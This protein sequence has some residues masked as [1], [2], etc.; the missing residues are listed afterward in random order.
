M[1]VGCMGSDD[2]GDISVTT[3]IEI[4]NGGAVVHVVKANKKFT[5]E[6]DKDEIKDFVLAVAGS[7]G[8]G[9]I[10][11]DINGKK[12]TIDSGDDLLIFKGIEVKE[13]TYDIS[14]SVLDTE[15]NEIESID[16]SIEVKFDEESSSS[17]MQSSDDNKSSEEPA[18]S[19]DD[20]QSSEDPM[21]SEDP[22]SSDDPKSSEDPMSSDDPKS[23]E[24]PMSSDDPKSSED[25]MSSEDPKSSE[26]PMSS[27]SDVVVS[28]EEPSSSSEEP[29]TDLKV[30]KLE[31]AINRTRVQEIADGSVIEIAAEDNET[32]NFYAT[33]EGGEA[34]SVK[35]DA[36]GWDDAR[37]EDV[38][39]DPWAAHGQ[40]VSFNEG[41]TEISLT[42]TPMDGNLEGEALSLTFTIKVP[43][44]PSSSSE[45]PTS[46]SSTTTQVNWKGLLISGSSYN[47]Y[48]IW[49]WD[50][51]RTVMHNIWTDYGIPQQNLIH[52]AASSQRVTNNDPQVGIVRKASD[53]A[54]R[55]GWSDLNIGDGDGCILF[56][57]S[58]GSK[59]GGFSISGSYPP[60]EMDKDLDKYCGDKPTI[61]FISACYSGAYVAGL[62]GS[63]TNV[64]APNRIV[65]TAARW[66]RSSYGCG[67]GTHMT[68]WDICMEKSLKAMTPGQ[69]TW[70]D[71]GKKMVKCNEDQ[72]SNMGD[73]SRSYPQERYGSGMKNYTFFAQ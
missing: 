1:L 27:S 25:P 12:T 67:S 37:A 39:P 28:S 62:G 2:D 65:Y 57:T 66:D 7:D 6:A 48:G 17:E 44:P 69:G 51:A 36:T 42:I 33:V 58:H 32:V 34:S 45:E 14:V 4:K 60:S 15:G 64:T 23:S 30:T 16:F 41:E 73:V 56:M 49:N 47:T 5:I 40:G 52:L 70:E 24:D 11:V 35:F 61:L 9:S 46:S 72:E 21:S 22:K 20:G 54:I 19:S 31:L 55:Q 38:T 3:T 43:P 13:G 26:D 53:D 29:T 68:Y 10:I 63:G 50:S 59:S 71:F 18:L 8:I